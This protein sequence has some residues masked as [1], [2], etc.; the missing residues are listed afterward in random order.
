MNEGLI[1]ILAVIVLSVLWVFRAMS[2]RSGSAH[3]DPVD[4]DA[5]PEPPPR[6]AAR[7]LG[8]LEVALMSFVEAEAWREVIHVEFQGRENFA[9]MILDPEGVDLSSNGIGVDYEKFG[10]EAARLGLTPKTY[11]GVSIPLTIGAMLD[12]DEGPYHVEIRGAWPEVAEQTI[13]MIEGVYGV[14]RSENVVVSSL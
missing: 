3:D 10:E 12:G 9:Q 14:E 5:I 4:L 7:P 11:E 1:P 13:R 2:R 6:A 8:E